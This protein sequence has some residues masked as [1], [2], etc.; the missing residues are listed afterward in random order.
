VP[1]VLPGIQTD[2]W[3]DN[4]RIREPAS[5]KDSWVAIPRIENPV[6]KRG[7]GTFKTVIF[8]I[9]YSHLTELIKIDD[10]LK[11][12]YYELLM[13]KT[14]PSVKELKNQI[15]SLSFERLGLSA[16]RAVAFKKEQLHLKRYN[17]KLSLSQ[18]WI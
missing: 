17:R 1:T 10:T 13:L 14:H 8:N 4:T 12:R 11:R 3:V 5:E 15:N 6:S 7:T 9:A 2:S 16:E 18:Q